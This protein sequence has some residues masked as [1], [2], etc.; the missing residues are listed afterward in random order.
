MHIEI[1]GS[2]C[3]KC[4]KTEANVHKA[5]EA[6]GIEAT[7]EKVTDHDEIASR[8]V[9]MTPAVAIDGEV[10]VAGKVPR[11][12]QLESIIQQTTGATQ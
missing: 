11:V 12:G 10:V 5:L 2:G 6:L 3:P 7:V 4:E 1:L 8:D 9:L